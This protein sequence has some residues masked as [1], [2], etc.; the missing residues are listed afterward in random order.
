MAHRSSA[1]SIHSVLGILLATSAYL[2]AASPLPKDDLHAAGY[3]YLMPRQCAVYCGNNNDGCCGAGYVC[4]TAENNV[5]CSATVGGGYV[6]IATTWTVTKTFTSSYSS[7]FPA[8]T[9]P[10]GTEKC[11]PPP[12]SGQIACGNICCA[13][14]QYC[15]YEG[16]CMAN[17]G[18]TTT[19]GAGGG[20]GGVIVPTTI[21]TGGQTITTQFSAPYRV[22]SGTVTSTGTAEPASTTTGAVSPG[23][24]SGGLSGGAI[25]GI[26]VG[27]I[28]GVALLL[29]ICACCVVR[30]LWHGLLALFGI[31]KKRR[32]SE[33]II[34]EERYTRRG[35][36]HSRRDTHGS[37]Y[38]GRPSTVAARK[39]KSKGAGLLGLGAALGTLALLLGLRRDKKEKKTVIKERSD[40]S[41]SYYTDSY[42]A[43]SPKITAADTEVH[44]FKEQRQ[45]NASLAA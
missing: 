6:V 28:A 29:L 25:A 13:N 39:E 30:G 5:G 7:F 12:G 31:G 23:G 33:T 22:T 20:G 32:D 3:G 27:T 40:I 42:T 44:R 11:V 17:V 15:A 24:T 38:G 9:A 14:W 43:T 36:T 2:A 35:S 21:T 37:W 26:V 1:L 10:A 41:S 4:Y 19:D 18:Y 34:E 16:Q 8:A 45:T